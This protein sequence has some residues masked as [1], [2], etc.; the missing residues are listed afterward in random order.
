MFIFT[1]T[2]D[3]PHE[4]YQVRA[5]RNFLSSEQNLPFSRGQVIEIVNILGE[6]NTDNFQNRFVW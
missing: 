1:P 5:Y 2:Y 6:I 3:E 4:S